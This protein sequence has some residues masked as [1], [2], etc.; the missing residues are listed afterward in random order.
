MTCNPVHTLSS[1]FGSRAGSD[2]HIL[3]S[4]H[5]C[6]CPWFLSCKQCQDR[7]T[8]CTFP[9]P[10][11]AAVRVPVRQSVL[12][13]LLLLDGCH[14]TDPSGP[15]HSRLHCF[16]K[17]GPSCFDLRTGQCA[18]PTVP[19]ATAGGLRV[20]LADDSLAAQRWS[21]VLAHLPT[22]GRMGSTLE[23]QFLQQNAILSGLIQ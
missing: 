20:P 3:D 4:S 14:W 1:R 16:G 15:S 6:Q 17:L 21:W 12:H 19:L 23:W 7:A 9:L 22:L 2:G 8:L 18:D 13:A 5:R 10:R 11:A